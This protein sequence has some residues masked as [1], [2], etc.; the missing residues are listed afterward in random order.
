MISKK[1]TRKALAASI[2]VLAALSLTLTACGASSSSIGNANNA[3]ESASDMTSLS[4][5]M[6]LS[7]TNA[8]GIALENSCIIDGFTGAWSGSDEVPEPGAKMVTLPSIDVSYPATWKII[9]KRVNEYQESQYGTLSKVVVLEGPTGLRVSVTLAAN[10][11]GGALEK[12]TNIEVIGPTGIEDILLVWCGDP[13][14]GFSRPQYINS[15]WVY[16]RETVSDLPVPSLANLQEGT[17]NCTISLPEPGKSSGSS[18]RK[19]YADNPDLDAAC[20]ILESVCLA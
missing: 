12:D 2:A 6:A 4:N 17:L 16:E 13:Q 19:N 15:K 7:E 18:D 10:V 14:Y 20:A 5:E 1:E 8:E 11:Y 9:E 3:S